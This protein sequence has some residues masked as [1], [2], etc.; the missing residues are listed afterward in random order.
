MRQLMWLF[1]NV[2]T[3]YFFSGT[4]L[5]PC[6]TRVASLERSDSVLKCRSPK[7]SLCSRQQ[8]C[9]RAVY[10]LY[11]RIERDAAA[12]TLNMLKDN[13]AVRG[14]CGNVV[15]SSRAPLSRCGCA[16]CAL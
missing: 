15:G 10:V 13:A 6:Y 16:A 14:R 8:R 11:H 7:R 9:L 1:L 3:E 5:K 2:I 12:I 4:Y